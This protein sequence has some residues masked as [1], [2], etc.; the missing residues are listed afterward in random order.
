MT[1]HVRLFHL[2]PYERFELAGYEAVPS[3][4]GALARANDGEAAMGL[5]RLATLAYANMSSCALFA[6]ASD[7][8]AP[9]SPPARTP[10]TALWMVAR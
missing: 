10:R 3:F 1:D 2:R 7:L 9:W 8:R 5:E 6:L 4:R